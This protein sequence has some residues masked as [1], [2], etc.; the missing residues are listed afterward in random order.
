MRMRQFLY[1][2]KKVAGTSNGS[3]TI[4]DNIIYVAIPGVKYSMGR[5]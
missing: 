2:G 4:E 5:R 3:T 1:E